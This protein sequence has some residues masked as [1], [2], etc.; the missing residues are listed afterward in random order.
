[1]SAAAQ[2]RPPA[3]LLEVDGLTR[4][5]GGVRAV[6][7]VS[8]AVEAG[9]VFGLIG[10]NGSGK[11][12]LINLLSG[13]LR[14]NRG[15]ITFG[16][17]DIAGARADVIARRGLGRTY[18]QIRLF[19]AL[20]ALE[21]VLVGAHARRCGPFWRWLCFLPGAL[22]EDALAR[23]RAAALLDDVGLGAAAGV[24][25]GALAYGDRRR[26]EIARALAGDPRLL[27]LDEPA[28]GMGHGEVQRLMEL[29]RSLPARGQTVLLVEHN[30]HVV[31]GV[32]R[33]IGVLNFGRLIALGA[34][35]AIRADPAVIE[36]YLGRD[37]DDD[38]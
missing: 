27:L 5:F 7:R 8:L 11:T 21:N 18:Q 29:I 33:R 24:P 13:F 15:T 35:S 36:A 12:T 14:P 23:E 1:M 34:P 32:C 6:D 37:D 20:T 28:A 25:A 2:A 26:L 38:E 30:M 10:P 3:P 4:S 16:G 31:M 9:E 22:R 19:P 17:R